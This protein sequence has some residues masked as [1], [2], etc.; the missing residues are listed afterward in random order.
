MGQEECVRGK[1]G[2]RRWVYPGILVEVC[3]H[4]YLD[5]VLIL[6][7]VQASLRQR[8]ALLINLHAH[9]HTD[10]HTHTHTHTEGNSILSGMYSHMRY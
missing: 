10:T 4:A 1:T 2:N 9:T 6:S 7:Q 5:T 3:T 8:E